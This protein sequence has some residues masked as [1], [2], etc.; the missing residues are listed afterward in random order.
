MAIYNIGT[1]TTHLI[2]NEI[3][4]TY[5]RDTADGSIRFTSSALFASKYKHQADADR[6]I[7]ELHLKDCKTVII[8]EPI[9]VEV[10]L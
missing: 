7:K 3:S 9:M 1:K 8:H 5:L 2:K 10:R 4:E 6:K